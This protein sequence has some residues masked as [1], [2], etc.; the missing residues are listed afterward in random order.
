VKPSYG[1]TD[2]EIAGMLREGVE[3]AGQDMLARALREQQVE[4]D[5]LLEATAQ[6]LEQDGDLLDATER[7]AIDA[8]I[9]AL[10]QAREGDDHRLIKQ[11]IDA[12]TR[13][14]DEFA[15]RRMDRSVRTALAGHKV[16]EIEL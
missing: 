16:D 7:S 14:T 12:L 9:A 4:A 6:A 3:H 11:H 10:R 1:L 15:A 13:A 5:R 2:E 8:A